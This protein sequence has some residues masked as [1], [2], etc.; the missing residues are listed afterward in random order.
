ME[1]EA[2][3]GTTTLERPTRMPALPNGK[4]K[5]GKPLPSINDT[6][7]VLGAP[8]DAQKLT[9]SRP[10]F[11]SAKIA[12]VGTTALVIHRFS[13]KVQAGIQETQEAGSVARKG[14][15]R[16]PRDFQDNYENARYRAK[17]GG[18]DG[19]PSSAFRNA[20]ISA[21]RTVG[22]KMTIAKMSVFCIPDGFCEDGTGLVKITK[23]V[24]HCDIRPGRNAN[25]GVDLRARPMWPEGWEATVHLR[26]DADQFSA[27]DLINLLARAGMQVGIC[28][29]RPDSKMSAGCGWGEFAIVE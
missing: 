22:F 23:G 24:P 13:Q 11:R 10:N 26:W 20:L 12:I 16:K 27:T 19:I 4:A 9:I 1:K 3:M 6:A 18:W 15:T 2:K 17:N 21:C 8:D 5:R 28:E 29:G 25:G 7:A 14:R